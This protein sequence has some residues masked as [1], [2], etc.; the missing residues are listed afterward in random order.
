MGYF[1]D[2]EAPAIYLKWAK[3]FWLIWAVLSVLSLLLFFS[4]GLFLIVSLASA[5]LGICSVGGFMFSMLYESH[6]LLTEMEEETL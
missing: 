1:D 3:R 6:K 2:T 5:Y 4:E